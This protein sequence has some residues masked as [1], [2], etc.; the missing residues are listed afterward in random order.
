MQTSTEASNNVSHETMAIN[1]N[2]IRFLQALMMMHPNLSAQDA[3]DLTWGGLEGTLAWTNN[4]TSEERYRINQTNNSF[5][6]GI[7]GTKCN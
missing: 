4:L 5:K 1:N 3:I 7:L 6:K 2:I